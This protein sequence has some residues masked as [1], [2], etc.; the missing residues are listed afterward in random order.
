VRL[1]KSATGHGWW[2]PMVLLVSAMR[3]GG[4]DAVAVRLCPL[5]APPL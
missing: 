2:W 5:I 4:E 1:R 3:E